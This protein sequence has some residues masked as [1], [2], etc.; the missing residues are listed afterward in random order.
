[1]EAEPFKAPSIAAKGQP[2]QHDR[3]RADDLEVSPF[4]DEIFRH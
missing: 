2:Y 4:P 3:F 1:M